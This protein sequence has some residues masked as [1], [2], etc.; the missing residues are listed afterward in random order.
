MSYQAAAG[1]YVIFGAVIFAVIGML[2]LQTVGSYLRR[3]ESERRSVIS[4]LRRQ[5][6]EW[7][8]TELT[9]I[10]TKERR[11]LED[12]T[13]VYR[14]KSAPP[15][16]TRGSADRTA[17]TEELEPEPLLEVAHRRGSRRSVRDILR[18]RE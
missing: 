5:Q 1:L 11:A 16:S 18:S 14:E 9:Y 6:G 13:R 4:D 8:G 17:R 10:G 15:Q 3:R 12:S 7:T 2:I